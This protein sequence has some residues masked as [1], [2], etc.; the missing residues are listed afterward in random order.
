[1]NRDANMGG[2]VVMIRLI[3][4]GL[5]LML[6]ATG[7]A[8]NPAT[9]YGLE[10]VS[11]AEPGDDL[12]A[13][14]AGCAYFYF[15]WGKSAENDHRY[16]EALEAYEKL[17]LCDGENVVALRTLATLL[18]RMDRREEALPWLQKLLDLEPG[19]VEA[20]LFLAGLYASLGKN[21]KARTQYR[22]LLEEDGGNTQ[23]LLALASL[24]AQEKEFDTAQELLQQLIDGGEDAYLGYYNLGRLYRQRQLF[25]QAIKAYEKALDL[26][27]SLPLAFELAELYEHLEDHER[28][29]RFYREVLQ[30]DE[31]SEAV[32]IRLINALLA[33]E[34][35]TEALAELRE[36]RSLSSSPEE[37]DIAVSRFLFA[38]EKYEQAITVLSRLL[39]ENPRSDT[40]RFLLAIAFQQQGALTQARELLLAIPPEAE[41]YEDSVQTLVRI[42]WQEEKAKEAIA[43]LFERIGDERHRRM[44]FYIMLAS[45]LREEGRPEQGRQILDQAL[46]VFPDNVTLLYEYGVFLEKIGDQEG[47]LAKMDEVLA[48]DS[49]NSQALN[50]IGYTWADN[51]V[52][53]EQALEYINRAV[54]L[55]PEDGYI[56]DSLGWVYYRLGQLVRAVEELEKAI[57][58]ADGDPVIYDHLG[59]VLRD[60]DRREEALEAYGKALER[61]QEEE[62][63]EAVRGKIETLR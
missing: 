27:W 38:R 54:A 57:T 10:P 34:R 45:L 4:L 46:T 6:L 53:L 51:G 48:L 35:E 7:C 5:C 16:E 19:D 52:N 30:E 60:L 59:D 31:G 63:K 47:A 49:D 32:R 2:I 23:A 28:A 26:H 50:Y 55:S 22:T 20:R 8:E 24:H 9:G 21:G 15:L 1:M 33:A 37:V 29:I 44:S 13:E 12:A 61:F 25:P 43:L 18:V 42:L 39:A 11:S 36:L 17:L 58:M 3:V 62:K 14:D 41:E 56:R 40:A